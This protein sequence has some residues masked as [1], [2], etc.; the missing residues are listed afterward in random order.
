MSAAG[1]RCRPTDATSINRARRSRHCLTKRAFDW[2]SLP[3]EEIGFVLPKRLSVDDAVE[4]R[5][6]CARVA[7]LGVYKS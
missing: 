2:N 3:S 1:K 5:F 7:R 4:V 6:S